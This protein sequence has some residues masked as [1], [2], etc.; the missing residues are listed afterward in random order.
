MFNH[1]LV[2]LDGSGLAESSLPAAV[3]L[4]EKLKA[5][6]TL[7][8]IIEKNPPSEVHGQHH[9]KNAVEASAYLE[10]ISKSWFRENLV[11]E[12]HV[13]TSEVDDVA[14]S[15]VEHRCEFKHDLVI[16]CSHGRGRAL[17]LLLGCIAQ[18][19][20][21]IGTVPVL[22]IQPDET[23]NIREFS[24]R[25]ILVPLDGDPAHGG[26]L[27]VS[28]EIAG[29][30]GSTLHL[31]MVIPVF[32]SI[33]GKMAVQSRFQP[34]ATSRMLDIL[35][36]NADEY[37]GERLADLKER[38]F[39]ASA[40]VLRGDPADLVAE[41]VSKSGVDLIVLATHGKSG[42]QAIWAGSMAHKICSL[43]RAPLLLVPV[44]KKE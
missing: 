22:L 27:P 33:P 25:S 31:L 37:L 41:S 14:E 13:H 28:E 2:P 21:A 18:N 16:M 4:A 9:I 40:H 42:M 38:G 39:Q 5:R 29:L 8:H 34:A 24:C 26:A 11:V 20:I 1:I 30:C 43:C 12:C 32:T 17:H 10:K 35:K 36:Q 44:E 15:I 3:F 23:K 7:I 19:V 6:V